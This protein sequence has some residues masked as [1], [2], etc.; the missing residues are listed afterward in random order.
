MTTLQSLNGKKV[1]VAGGRGLVGSAI[2]R[3]ITKTRDSEVLA[4]SRNELDLHNQQAVFDWFKKNQPEVVFMAAAKVGGIHANNS[5]PVDF[6][7]ENLVIETNVIKAAHDSGVEKLVFLG[8]SCIYPKEADIPISESSLL[9]G[10]LEP[11]NQWYAIAKI[12]GLKLCEAFSKQH[13]SDFISAMPCNVYGPFDNF[14][15]NSSHVLPALIR[16]FDEA[17]AKGDKEVVLWGTGKPLREFIFVNDLA[18]ALVFLAENKD[19]KGLINVG[20]GNDCSI[21]ELAHLIAKTVG[22]EGEIKHDLSKPDGVYRKLMDNA[23]IQ[24]LGWQP[25]TSLEDGIKQTYEWYQS[26]KDTWTKL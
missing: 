23:K 21:K 15:L 8:S 7:Y 25:K 17:K 5:F 22:F 26:N 6:L 9:T 3:Q 4:P 10:S 13:G 24:N 18:D 14:D 2:C 1:F 11:T 20:A 12:A 16:K 19:A